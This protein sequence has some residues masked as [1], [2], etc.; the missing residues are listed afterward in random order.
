MSDSKCDISINTSKSYGISEL[1]KE[2]E[3]KFLPN[4][5]SIPLNKVKRR[6]IKGVLTNDFPQSD[7]N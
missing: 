4:E 3:F 5:E 1:T 6:V 2:N 7:K